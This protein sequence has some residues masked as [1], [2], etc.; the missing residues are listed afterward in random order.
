MINGLI[1]KYP[2]SITVARKSYQIDTDFRRWIGFHE[3]LLDNALTSNNKLMLMY[4]LFK[5]AIPSM[6]YEKETIAQV[7]EFLKGNVMISNQK[8][9]SKTN[10]QVFSYTYDQEYI[11]GAFL[12][13][14]GID[15][16]NIEYLHWYHFCALLNALNP[17][18]E[19][20]QR[21]M[22]RSYD[23]SSIKDKNER[24][25]IKKIQKMI[26]L[27][28]MKIELSDEDIANAF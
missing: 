5:D 16:I 24:K 22:Y 13:C 21:I 9:N 27:P 25:R 12:E 20:K 23:L 1:E 15:L 6:I 19:L 7:A 2:T 4:Q 3:A 26:E 8:D 11:I 28:Q 17:N 10:K 14:Y 18:C